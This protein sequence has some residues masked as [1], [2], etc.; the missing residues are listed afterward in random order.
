MFPGYNTTP[1]NAAP[2]IAPPNPTTPGVTVNIFGSLVTRGLGMRRGLVTRGL[3]GGR[4]SGLPV[5]VE[6]GRG[7]LVLAGLKQMLVDAGI[8][9]AARVLIALDPEPME[10]P[11]YNFLV[12]QP[13]PEEERPLRFEGAE[14]NRFSVSGRFIVHVIA[15]SGVD[16]AYSDEKRLIESTRGALAIAHAVADALHGKFVPSDDPN[17]DLTDE[18]IEFLSQS[19]PLPY[20]GASKNHVRVP[21]TFGYT[22]TRKLTGSV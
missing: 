12:I 20:R 6:T 7:F 4:P 5:I 2:T 13:G 3:K 16:I 10:K 14:R 15:S 9:N 21:I 19:Q 22:Y 17:V 18:P 8:V 11:P 1:F